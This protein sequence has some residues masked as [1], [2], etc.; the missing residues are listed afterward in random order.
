MQV[1]EVTW[2]AEF[3]ATLDAVRS[4]DPFLQKEVAKYVY[5]RMYF[6]AARRRL[7]GIAAELDAVRAVAIAATEDRHEALTHG[8]S[9]RDDPSWAAAA[10]IESWAL[11]KLGATQGKFSRTLA[12]STDRELGRVFS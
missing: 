4:M 12:E 9:G 10:L 3:Q 7:E 5:D 11:A 2:E 8:A 6:V 1:T